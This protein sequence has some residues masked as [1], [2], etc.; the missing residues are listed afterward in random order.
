MARRLK[1][2][3]PS[4]QEGIEA[5]ITDEANIDTAPVTEEQPKKRGR[6]KKEFVSLEDVAKTKT[7]GNL[8]VIPVTKQGT[9]LSKVTIFDGIEDADEALTY[10]IPDTDF[11]LKGNGMFTDKTSNGDTL[12]QWIPREDEVFFSEK[13]GMIVASYLTRL[14]DVPEDRQGIYYIIAKK[15]YQE[16]IPDLLQHI[17]YF[18][19]HYDAEHEFLTSS[20]SVK[21]FIDR[22]PN[23]SQKIFRKMVIG[24]IITPTL[25]S[26]VKHMAM[27]LYRLNINTDAD[28]KYKS[29]PK[30]T[31]DNARMIV[32]VS[33]CIRLILPLCIHFSNT[34]ST[35]VN[36]RDY[37]DCFDRIFMDVVDEFEKGD[38]EIWNP[39]CRFVAYRVERSYTS[40]LIIWEKKKQLYG[41]TLELYLESLIHEV[42]LVKSLHKLTYSRSVVS[43][44]DGIIS[45]SYMH[46]RYENFKYKPVEIEVEDTDSDDRMSHAETLEMAICRVDEANQ[47]ISETNI[48]QTMAQL[49]KR[50]NVEISDEEFN[51]Y[52]DNVKVNR[53]SQSLVHTFFS[54]YFNDTNAVQLLDR[55]DL[56]RLMIYLKK[57]LQMRGMQILA[58]IL[59][60]TVE[61]KFKDACIKNTKFLETFTTSSVYVHIISTKY[62]Y[63]KELGLKE[64][65]ITKDL[66]T[67]INSRFI[68][69]DFD[70]RINGVVGED[71]DRDIIVS[72]FMLFLS[73]C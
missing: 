56:I 4:I 55:R 34:N 25:V 53:L 54:K 20:L 70:Q 45:H 41:T 60:A 36:K 33:F 40:D 11:T 17:N 63:I 14:Y 24:R 50:F 6:K 42:I 2:I 39:I 13:D 15:H 43:F 26:K 31:N 32:A 69:C 23:V 9:K 18:I 5:A 57:F 19:S 46:Y 1:E 49:A 10:R 67:M 29:T 52:L 72:D 7:D 38:T 35:F 21:N 62:R 68:F 64:D 65:P 12:M 73:I 47:L 66:S 44:I 58:Q 30:I 8:N 37:I 16:R 71:I 3:E 28:G 48:E 59:T 51:F 61:G 27:D 22:H